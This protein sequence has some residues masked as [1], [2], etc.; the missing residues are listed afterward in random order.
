MRFGI[1]GKAIC[2]VGVVGLV[3][4]VFTAE[5]AVTLTSGN[6]TLA[7]DTGS[8]AGAYNWTVD[9]T[10]QLYQQWFWYRIGAAGPESSIDALS[11]ANV[12]M[13][14]ADMA[15]IT[16]TGASLK[17]EVTYMLNGGSEGSHQSDVG[18][19]IRLTNLTASSM[20]LHFFQYSDFDLGNTVNDDT[21]TL[22]YPGKVRQADGPGGLE[23]SETSVIAAPGHYELGFFANTLNKLNDANPTTL[24]DGA[25][26][27]GPGDV[28]WAFEW[29]PTLAGNGTYLISKD[30][31]ME[32]VPEP[33]TLVLL[34]G[35]AMSLLLRRRR[36]K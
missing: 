23:L 10:N 27:L 4:A 15:R 2:L 16:Y 17:V 31:M 24:S 13:L 12:Q 8:S 33:A 22:V 7:I 5:A 3:P 36:A 21:V 14:G 18:E 32:P 20:D 28:T 35:G 25:T 34:A 11:T 19:S 30:K 6:S 29:D 26:T 9:G 1:L